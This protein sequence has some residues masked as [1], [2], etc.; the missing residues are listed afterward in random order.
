MWVGGGLEN[1][2]AGDGRTTLATLAGIGAI[3]R[4]LMIQ[5]PK[6]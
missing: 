6:N 2:H 3:S 1:R 5:Q 4:E